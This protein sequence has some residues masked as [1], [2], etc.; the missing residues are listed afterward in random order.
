V[1]AALSE[2]SGDSLARRLEFLPS[3]GVPV[4]LEQ[5]GKSVE[6]FWPYAPYSRHG[7]PEKLASPGSS[8]SFPEH[9][10]PF[11]AYFGAGTHGSMMAWLG[12]Q[13][14][15]GELPVGSP[16]TQRLQAI[17]TALFW[18]VPMQQVSDDRMIARGMP[19]DLSTPEAMREYLRYQR[20]AVATQVSRQSPDQ[21][22]RTYLRAGRELLDMV[23]AAL[24][25]VEGF[26]EGDRSPLS[27]TPLGP[28]AWYDQASAP[29]DANALPAE[30]DL[31]ATPRELRETASRLELEAPRHP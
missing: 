4:R 22:G 1:D 10:A 24:L 8:E 28:Y 30:I 14:S 12:E 7:G 21:D 25:R 20:D 13:A 17:A 5:A 3:P 31:N 23:D 11:A 29:G 15:R 9:L 26:L 27:V 18:D 16:A 19:T 2:R 6:I